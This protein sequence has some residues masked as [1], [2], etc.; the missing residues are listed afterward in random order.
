MDCWASPASEHRGRGRLI[1]PHNA[2]SIGL[3]R[4]RSRAG[5]GR[6]GQVMPV[7]R[8]FAAAGKINGRRICARFMTSDIGPTLARALESTTAQVSA[9]GERILT[10]EREV[11][12]IRLNST[13]SESRVGPTHG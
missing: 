8:S 12:E 2:L 7:C 6:F 1:P 10:P 9:V 4:D 13:A 5:P 11:M 3:F